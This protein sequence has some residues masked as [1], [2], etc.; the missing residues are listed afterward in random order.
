[1]QYDSYATI[2]WYDHNLIW[3]KNQTQYDSFVMYVLPLLTESI[4][5]LNGITNIYISTAKT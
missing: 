1:M 3:Y 5:H 4:Y 2:L